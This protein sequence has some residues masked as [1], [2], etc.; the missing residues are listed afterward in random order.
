MQMRNV[1]AAGLAV[2]A[3]I[4]PIQ[5][6]SQILD[7]QIAEKER[8]ANYHFH[9][10][11]LFLLFPI[12]VAPTAWEEEKDKE[13]TRVYYFMGMYLFT[14]DSSCLGNLSGIKQE[15]D[16]TGNRNGKESTLD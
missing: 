13:E 9:L 12:T 14:V 6:L 11:L 10:H 2:S 3:E 5:I 8:L 4:C 16:K 7:S 15:W 1:G